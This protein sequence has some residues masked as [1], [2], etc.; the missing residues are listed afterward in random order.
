MIHHQ[1]FHEINKLKNVMVGIFEESQDNN[2]NNVIVGFIMTI[3]VRSFKIHV[4]VSKLK[5][6]IFSELRAFIRSMLNLIE[7]KRY[8]IY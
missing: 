7:F 4:M 5:I 1:A 3:S 6:N 8:Y 2:P